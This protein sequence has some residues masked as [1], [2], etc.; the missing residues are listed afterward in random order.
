MIALGQFTTLLEEAPVAYHPG[1]TDFFTIP[2]PD[3]HPDIPNLRGILM[4]SKRHL[5]EGGGQIMQH[6]SRSDTY[7]KGERVVKYRPLPANWD[8]LNDSQR[9]EL[10][11]YRED[12]ARTAMELGDRIH[13]NQTSSTEGN[14][15]AESVVQGIIELQHYGFQQTLEWIPGC[16]LDK[17]IMNHQ[18]DAKNTTEAIVG[19]LR[20]LVRLEALNI[21]HRDIKPANLVINTEVPNKITV[22]DTELMTQASTESSTGF[23]GTPGFLPPYIFGVNGKYKNTHPKR[24]YY[25]TAITIGHIMVDIL[26]TSTWHK[27]AQGHNVFDYEKYKDIPQN[28]LA[29]RN[30]TKNKEVETAILAHFKKLEQSIG[31]SAYRLWQIMMHIL[32]EGENI[33]MT[34]A[35]IDEFA[36]ATPNLSEI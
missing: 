35:I 34:H 5:I 20:L 25:S 24:D 19:L 12:L 23:C 22:I 28:I 1:N 32:K 17:L 31:T 27:I 3:P 29:I 4:D 13:K 7:R 21:V 11:T 30:F 2:H 15:R 18:L 36:I 16:D 6:R 9:R 8:Y 26:G 33:K 14:H 10:L